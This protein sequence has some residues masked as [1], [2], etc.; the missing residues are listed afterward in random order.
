MKVSKGKQLTP[1]KWLLAGT[2]GIGK[3]TF[4]ATCPAPLFASCEDGANE[5]DVA[6]VQVETLGDFVELVDAL[7]TDAQKFEREHDLPTTQ[8]LVIDTVDALEGLIVD[9]VCRRNKWGNIEDAGYGKGYV[10]V[11]AEWRALLAKI[12]RMQRATKLQVLSIGHVHVKKYTPPDSEPYDRFDIKLNEKSSA[13]L[14]EWHD[15]VFFAQHEVVVA[16][17]N[18]ESKKR[19]FATG[20]RVIRTEE[21]AAW[22]AKNRYG[23]PSTMRLD[24]GTY[25]EIE[26]HRTRD[27]RADLEALLVGVDAEKAAKARA[28]FETQANKSLALAK[29][30]ERITGKAA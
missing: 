5:L 28:W 16:K 29:L 19:G 2:E 14:R 12:E 24:A 30:A 10:A 22:R 20:D 15:A 18:G 7:T 17:A 1:W 4:G 3:T 6:R 9:D 27:H 13:I 23:L 8:T 26:K 21:T 11:H 25:A